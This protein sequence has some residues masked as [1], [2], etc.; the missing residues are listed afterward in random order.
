[1]TNWKGKLV[2]SLLTYYKLQFIFYALNDIC[3]I[4][5]FLADMRHSG[6]I[7]GDNVSISMLKNVTD[8]IQESL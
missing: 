7:F 6:N 2:D 5:Y 1:M 4:K 8:I 3:L